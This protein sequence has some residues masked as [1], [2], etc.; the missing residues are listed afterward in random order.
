MA[1][2]TDNKPVESTERIVRT[3]TTTSGG[4]SSPAGA[5]SAASQARVPGRTTLSL[6]RHRV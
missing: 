5:S 1:N 6:F 3:T 2:E 4:V